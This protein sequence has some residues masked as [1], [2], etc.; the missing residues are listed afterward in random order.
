M[1]AAILITLFV[2]V[3]LAMDSMAQEITIVCDGEVCATTRATMQALVK[4]LERLRGLV[5]K[6]CL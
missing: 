1:K 5:G 6:Q 4:E 2:V 3:I